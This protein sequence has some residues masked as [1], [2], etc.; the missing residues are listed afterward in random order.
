MAHI[1]FRKT[2]ILPALLVLIFSNCAT[3]ID[4]KVQRPPT[5]NTAG[6]K[7]IAIMPFE[8]V[9]HDRLYRE[10]A[11]Y[12]TSAAVSRINAMNYFT[13]VDASEIERL[14]NN[15]QSIE[16][17]VDALFI[18]KITR[19]ESKD[20]TSLGQTKNKEGDIIYYTIFQR[21]VEIEF[22]YSVMRSRDGSLIGPV[23]RRGSSSSSSQNIGEVR[24]AT[25]LLRSI[26]DRQLGPLGR[27]IAPYTATES[28]ELAKDTSKDK[29]LQTEMKNAL[30]Q[31]KARNY[32]IA[33][34][35]YLRIYDKYNSFAAAENAS[36]LH[37]TLGDTLAAANLMQRVFEETG[38]PR[39]QEVLA[40]LNRILQ[41]KATVANEYT[42]A[43]NQTERVAAYASD[44]IQKVLPKD[45]RVWIYN[46]AVTN[47]LAGA[48]VDNIT[49]VFV[50]KGIRVVDRQNTALI[51]AEQQLQMSGYVSD[52]DFVSIGNAAGANTI[53]IIGIIGSGA[54]RRLQVQ[55]LDIEKSVTIMQSD[56]DERWK[57]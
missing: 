28:R 8:T 56:T 33:R 25:D 48:V 52:D 9:S 34:E 20:S 3:T 29:A 41:D 26:V 2:L 44:E 27:D 24:S 40:R 39:A 55:V 15:N 19:L 30:D 13:L 42:D 57:L 47:P 32:L 1:S 51:E 17:Y 11:Q 7:R 31:V 4:L 22:N 6:I 5:L 12:V 54:I 36:I 16:N 10:M 53:V 49:S 45:A 50:R 46:N 35:A 18:G 38:N 37:E 23:T 14:R 21:D 43:P